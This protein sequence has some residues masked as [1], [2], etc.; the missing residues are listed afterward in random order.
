[1]PA[2]TPVC[3]ALSPCNWIRMID[4]FGP[5][6]FGIMPIT[7]ISKGSMLSPAKMVYATPLIPGLTWSSGRMGG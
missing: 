2:T 5:I 4:C 3:S 6:R 7:S 1:M